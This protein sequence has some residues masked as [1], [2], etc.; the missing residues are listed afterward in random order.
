MAE[1]SHNLYK[2]INVHCGLNRGFAPVPAVSTAY[3]SETTEAGI[4]LAGWEFVNI[5]KDC[6]SSLFSS[7]LFPLL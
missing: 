2:S 5:F 7:H 1:V 3:T 6:V 4:I